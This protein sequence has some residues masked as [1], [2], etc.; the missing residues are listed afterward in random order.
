MLKSKK[1]AAEEE[2]NV[3][4]TPNTARTNSSIGRISHITEK[5]PRSGEKNATSI[6][7]NSPYWANFPQKTY[8]MGS[9][10]TGGGCF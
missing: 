9:F 3:P 2:V 10:L 8:D 1:Y 6:W 4:D 7:R 5:F